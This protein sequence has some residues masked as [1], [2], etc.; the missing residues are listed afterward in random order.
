MVAIIKALGSAGAGGGA[1]DAARYFT[2]LAVADYYTEGGEPLG[3]WHGEGA[4]LLGLRGAPNY[5]TLLAVLSGC[6]PTT[7]QPMILVRKPKR[8]SGPDEGPSASEGP[9]QAKKKRREHCPAI[10]LCLTLPED[11]SIAWAVGG[12]RVRQAI[13]EAVDAASKRLVS[14]IEQNIPLARRG[15]HGVEQQQAKL[16]VALFDHGTSRAVDPQPHRH[17]HCVIAN[18]CQGED[19][20]WSA[21]NTRALFDWT[22][23]LGPVYR[24]MV[25]AELKRRIRLPLQP[26]VDENKRLRGW[27]VI[28]GI[29]DSLRK[30]WSSRHDEIEQLVAGDKRLSGLASAN[31][32]ASA[33]IKT[34]QAKRKQPPRADLHATWEAEAAKHGLGRDQ[35]AAL[36]SQ[37]L[38]PNPPIDPYPGALRQAMAELTDAESHVTRQELIQ[39]T[40]ELLSHTG[41]DG[42][43]MIRRIDRDLLRSPEIVRLVSADD[44][45]RYTTPRMWTLEKKLLADTDQLLAGEGAKVSER[46]IQRELARRETATPEQKRA[47][48]ALLKSQAQVRTLTGVA[49][50]G[51]TFVLDA[52]RA[53][54][55]R[56]GYRVLGGALSGIAKE[57]L[58]AQANI[59]SRTI[60]SYLWHLDRPTKG[61]IKDLVRHHVRQLWRAARG[62]PTYAPEK[63]TLRRKNVLI[64]DEAGMLDTQTMSRC[65]HHA[66]KCGATVILVGD[67]KQLAPIGAGAPFER[68]TTIVNGPHLGENRRQ[69]HAIDRNAVKLLREGKGSEALKLYAE[70]GRLCIGKNKLDTMRKLVNAWTEAGG[71]KRPQDYLILTQTRREAQV[72]NQR[73]QRERQAKRQVAK[74]GGVRVAEGMIYRGD[75]VLFHKAYRAAGVENGHQ[76]R[77]LSVNPLTGRI[78]IRLDH[79]VATGLDDVKIQPVVVV[80]L[81]ALEKGAIGLAYAATAHKMQGRTAENVFM[82]LGGKMV[83]QALTYVSSTRARDTTRIFVD[84]AHAGEN[85]QDLA[86]TIS[87]S[88]AKQ[89]A[90]DL[91]DPVKRPLRGPN[92]EIER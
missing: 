20:R 88:R 2:E 68:I 8:K 6:H 33:Q 63:V 46:V 37:P 43:E 66:K 77:V 30:V 76:G 35:V 45:P 83:D 86:K 19:G 70:S 79:W 48:E 44:Q 36:V 74:H 16:V 38:E 57:E 9:D 22:R 47:I 78:T 51:K 25:T 50:S 54:L 84:E 71:I 27:A 32:K 69:R 92:L 81:R 60:A 59:P 24:C 1:A 49:G 4:K 34:R 21:V 67:P 11:L 29:P 5:E 52:V 39:R 85:L 62:R 7:R 64:I 75:R 56:S 82:L 3:Q 40:A 31:A 42:L 91:V 26:A 61:R 10:D 87:R 89:L 58:A 12:P 53:A 72:L 28:P 65:L 41:M 18:L 80:P 23:A 17:R 90:H 55:E 15:R 14:Y 73:C 13:D